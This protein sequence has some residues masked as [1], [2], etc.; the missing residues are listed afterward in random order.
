MQNIVKKFMFSSLLMMFILPNLQASNA[1]SN[2]AARISMLE[3]AFAP[4]TP[5]ALAELFARANK[6]RNGAV[7]FMMFSDAIKNQYKNNWPY[8]VSGSSSPWI[9]S[10]KIKKTML[11]NQHWQYQITYDWATAAGPFKPSLV[12]TIDVQPVDK[13]SSSTQKFQITKIT[14]Q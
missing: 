12:Q 5:D 4:Q 10:Y 8:W 7:Q 6:E 13:E 11:G 2:D 9:T 14:P 3:K 1:T